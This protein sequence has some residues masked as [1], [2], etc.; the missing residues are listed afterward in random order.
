L[1]DWTER[2]DDVIDPDLRG[3]LAVWRAAQGIKPGDRSLTGPAPDDDR[4]AA[5]H[6]H[7]NR[8]INAR[9]GE[10]LQVWETKISTTPASA[11]SRRSFWPSSSTTSPATA[12]TPTAS[13][14]SPPL[15]SRCR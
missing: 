6:R 13:S 3:D 5:Y 14:T 1:P 12:I 15:E 7:V 10:A 4:E 11:T 9:Y 2:Y 8:N